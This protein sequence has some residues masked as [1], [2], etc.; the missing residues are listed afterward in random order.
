MNLVGDLERLFA[1]SLYPVRVPI[2]IAAALGLLTVVI[3]ARRRGW[4]AAAR[5]HPRRTG[6]LVAAALA[7]GLPVAWYLASPSGHPDRA[8]RAAAGGRHRSRRR[9]Q[10]PALEGHPRRPLR[11]ATPAP[12]AHRPPHRPSPTIHAAGTFH[13]ADDFHFGAGPRRSSRRPR[14]GSRSDSTTSPSA[15]GRTC[16]STSRRTA[17][18][19]RTARSSSGRS[20]RPTAP[21]GYE[22]PAGTDPADYASAVVW[23]KQFARPLRRR[24]RCR[25]RTSMARPTPR[26]SRV[27]ASVK[28]TAYHPARKR[29]GSVRGQN[30]ARR[31]SDSSH[32]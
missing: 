18:A 27:Y 26:E 25:Q 22:L 20:R 14:A 17:T 24:A 12:S 31:N 5:R 9:R 29:H 28:C 2:A 16:T 21:F 3:V 6:S 32:G 4:F 7:V 8:D 11:A 19:T 10:P 15:T 23:C 30:V 1:T 13:G